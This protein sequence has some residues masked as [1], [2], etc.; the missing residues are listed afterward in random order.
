MGEP[1][2]LND[3]ELRTWEGFLAVATILN[4]SVEQQLREVAGLSHSQYELLVRLAGAPDGSLRMTELAGASLTS[5]SGLTYQ[6]DQLEKAGLVRRSASADDDRGV[7]ASITEV[8]W[9]RL[10]GAAPG[11]AALVRRLFLDGLQPAE[12]EGLAVGV[13]ALL[14]WLRSDDA[15][16]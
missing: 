8:G 11:H 2:W 15:A 16:L 4:R 10:R 13:A 14:R 6:V 5:K 12:F 9:E 3:R 1:P 7:L